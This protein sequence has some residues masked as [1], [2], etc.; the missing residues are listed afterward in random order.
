MQVARKRI[1]CTGNNGTRKMEF[2][3]FGDREDDEQ[4]GAG[5]VATSSILVTQANFFHHLKYLWKTLVVS[6]L[7]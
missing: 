7:V 4:N 5:F 1:D 2:C 6:N 3:S